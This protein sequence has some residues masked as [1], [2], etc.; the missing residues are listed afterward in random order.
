VKLA[1]ILKT[2]IEELQRR[3]SS[4]EFTIWKVLNRRGELP[5]DYD[6]FGMV[7]AAVMNAGFRYPKK[8]VGADEFRPKVEEQKTDREKALAISKRVVKVPA[9]LNDM[10]WNT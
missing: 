1:K 6:L 2:P 9:L 10:T 5:D 4:R 3:M 7:A 8:P